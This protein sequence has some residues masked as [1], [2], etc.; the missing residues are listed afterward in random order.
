MGRILSRKHISCIVVIDENE[1]KI[2]KSGH[3]SKSGG[4]NIDF[5]Y[6]K[7]TKKT[8]QVTIDRY[9]LDN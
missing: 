3:K 6:A 8:I 9:T 7:S 2:R 5:R 1:N 4:I